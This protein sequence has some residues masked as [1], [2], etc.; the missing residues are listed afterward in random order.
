VLPYDCR[1]VSGAITLQCLCL[2]DT[3]MQRS[4]H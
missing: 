3:L 4:N 1:L 2:Q